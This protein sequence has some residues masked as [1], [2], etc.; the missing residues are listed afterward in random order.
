MIAVVGENAADE[1]E[2]KNLACLNRGDEASIEAD[3]LRGE[4][5]DGDAVNFVSD[6]GK[7]LPGPQKPNLFEAKG[8]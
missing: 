1:A 7:N 6:G 4:P 3:Q 5:H 8:S 2:D